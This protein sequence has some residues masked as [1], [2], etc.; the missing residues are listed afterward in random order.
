MKVFSTIL[1]L[2]LFQGC[3]SGTPEFDKNKVCSIPALK[4]LRNPRNKTKTFRPKP[5]L[6]QEMVKTHRDM[7]LC[8]E[9]FRYRS[10]EEEFSTCLVVGVN[11][12]GAREFINFGSQEVQLDDHFI[13][14]A[15]KVV[16]SVPYE[17][18]GS[19]YV[20]IQS[21]QFFLK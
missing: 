13:S 16:Q 8:Y 21:Y 17:N 7:Q 20:L 18:F 11:E 9:D 3:T 15:T 2:L 14:C 5:E 1:I 10:G 12:A 6:I 19:N 4:Y